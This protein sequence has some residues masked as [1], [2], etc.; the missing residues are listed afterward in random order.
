MTIRSIEELP[1]LRSRLFPA[2]L[3]QV[4][5]AESVHRRK[6]FLY[7]RNHG[8]QQD[9]LRHSPYSHLFSLKPEFPRQ[10][11]G[12][13]APV[14]KQFRYSALGHALPPFY[15]IYHEYILVSTKPCPLAA[16]RQHSGLSL[17]LDLLQP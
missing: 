2:A 17:L 10:P 9:A 14:P 1:A 16:G 5:P 6:P 15:G 7:V 12:L 13:A 4:I 8:L 11:H 3:Q